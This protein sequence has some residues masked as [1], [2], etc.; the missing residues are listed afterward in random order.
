MFLDICHEW[1]DKSESEQ[2]YQPFYRAVS[3]A[4]FSTGTK[5]KTRLQVMNRVQ[6]CLCN[7]NLVP[8]F[9][10]ICNE[11][12]DKPESEQEYQP[13]YRAVSAA[14][15]STG[16]QLK[17]KVQV[18]NRVQFCLC[19]MNLVTCFQDICNEWKDKSESEQEY[20]PFNRAVSA[21]AFSKLVLVPN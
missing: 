21:A 2:E 5:L 3:A 4:A 10:D 8:C 6:F 7:M 17:T 16:T 12:K 15:F 18:K 11:W 13:F 19:N 1:K 9:Q 14:A 20:Q